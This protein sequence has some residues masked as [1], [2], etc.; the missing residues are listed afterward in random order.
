MPVKEECHEEFNDR[1]FSLQ[2]SLVY[3][4]SF[5]TDIE[6]SQSFKHM[7]LATEFLMSNCLAQECKGQTTGN[8]NQAF[9]SGFLLYPQ[10]TSEKAHQ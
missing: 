8:V 3:L 10:S 5:V 4:Q 1:A 6:L 2:F 7:V 9:V